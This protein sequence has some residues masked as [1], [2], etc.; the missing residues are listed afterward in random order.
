MRKPEKGTI[1][2]SFA[3]EALPKYLTLQAL[4][5]AVQHRSPRIRQDS[6]LIRLVKGESLRGTF[7]ML[8]WI[9]VISGWLRG[10]D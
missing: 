8:G 5:I 10:S 4:S 7:D 1:I 9:A 2:R 6:G 3:D